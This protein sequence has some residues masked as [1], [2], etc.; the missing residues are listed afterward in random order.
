MFVSSKHFNKILEYLGVTDYRTLGPEIYD[1]K[2]GVFQQLK[3]DHQ[4]EINFMKL[5]I[6]EARL[7]LAA[8]L[9]YQ[10][11]E[12]RTGRRVVAIKGRKSKK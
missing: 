3:K 6:K 7:D 10:G 11:L 12:I 4:E 8:V 2:D 1:H 9:D 5:Q